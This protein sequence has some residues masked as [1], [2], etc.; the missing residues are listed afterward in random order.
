MPLG[1]SFLTELRMCLMNLN[2]VFNEPKQENNQ[3]PFKWVSNTLRITWPEEK[4]CLGLSVTTWIQYWFYKVRLTMSRRQSVASYIISSAWKMSSI[5]VALF[6]SCAW[7]AYLVFQSDG[8]L[9]ANRAKRFY[10]LL[11]LLLRLTNR[12]TDKWTVGY[13]SVHVFSTKLLIEYS[14]CMSHTGDGMYILCGHLKPPKGQ[15]LHFSVISRP[16]VWSGP[17]NP[18]R[19]LPLKLSTESAYPTE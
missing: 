7:G 10:S 14:I 4:S 6:Q 15:V 9:K 16:W 17:G 11:C 19:D 8:R 5:I 13:L 2:C 12:I 1:A 3:L 18:T